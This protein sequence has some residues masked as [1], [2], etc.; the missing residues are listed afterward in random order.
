MNRASTVAIA[1]EI[2]AESKYFAYASVFLTTDF[3]DDTDL[4]G[5]IG[6]FQIRAYCRVNPCGADRR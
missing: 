5:E 3:T 6:L 2:N 4:K 1:L